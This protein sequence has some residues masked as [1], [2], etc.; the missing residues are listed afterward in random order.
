MQG[1]GL[2][3]NILVYLNLCLKGISCTEHTGKWTCACLSPL[4]LSQDVYGFFPSNTLWPI[5][6]QSLHKQFLTPA[7]VFSFCHICVWGSKISFQRVTKW[8][9]SV[10]HWL[11]LS[12]ACIQT[13][14]S[15]LWIW[16]WIGFQKVIKNSVSNILHH[17]E[18]LRLMNWA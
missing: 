18:A 13:A 16:R 5:F 2:Y 9:I 10:Q 15:R 11:N 12:G 7:S 17:L 3:A 1:Y 8:W 14:F 6:F 4:S